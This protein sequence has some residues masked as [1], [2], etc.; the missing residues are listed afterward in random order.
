MTA[1]KILLLVLDGASDRPCEALNGLT[2]LQ[3]ADTPV[4]DRFAAGGI[5]GM[6]DTIAPGIRPGSDT[7]HLSL[8]GYPPEKYYTGRGPLE[9]EGAGIHME[10]G[11]I[12]FRAN[13]AT[14]DENG[15][16]TDRRAGRIQETA[17]LSSAIQEGVDL[18]SH[19]TGFLFESG[20]GHRA[21]FALKGEDLGAGVTSNDPKYEGMPPKEIQPLGSSP[22]DAKTARACNDFIRQ[23]A[24]ILATH[25]LN[26]CRQED[27]LPPANIILIRGAGKMGHFET[28]EKRHGLRGSVISSATLITGIGKV[29]GLRQATPAGV[30]GSVAGISAKIAA[31][32]A[33]LEERDFVLMNIKGADEKGHDGDPVAKM[34][35]IAECDTALRDLVP[36]DDC[37]V[38]ICCDHSTPCSIKD[39]S[40]DPVPLVI[41]GEGVRIDDVT[42][43]DEI[44]CAGGGLNRI[45]GRSLMPILL[46]L[47]NK[48]DKYGA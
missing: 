26:A 5:C 13:F 38:V 9:A 4:L 42:H 6:M 22:S 3:A 20:K 8:I 32:M 47:I 17:A 30:T 12:G 16:I 19:G 25:P 41:S 40:A 34:R 23:S 35:F 1:S 10:E 46:D 27:G 7:A 33:E 21:A 15:V 36:G 45:L 37:L 11:M 29:V 14:I 44:S 28:F 48:T 43:F 31:A 18:S 2:P 24:E 39:H